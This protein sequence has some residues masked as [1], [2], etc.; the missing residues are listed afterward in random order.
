MRRWPSRAPG[1]LQPEKRTR[2][3]QQQRKSTHSR[4][5]VAAA[6]GV[7]LFNRDARMARYSSTSAAASAAAARMRTLRS[8]REKDDGGTGEGGKNNKKNQ[9]ARG[10]ARRARQLK[11]APSRAADTMR[12]ASSSAS[13]RIASSEAPRRDIASEE[14]G[15]CL[16]KKLS[17][18][19]KVSAPL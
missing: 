15:G 4:S 17:K 7:E 1:P 13:F 16:V 2:A 10:A 18:E 11:R 14:E 5:S 3:L 8:A 6:S 9:E 19:R 12:V